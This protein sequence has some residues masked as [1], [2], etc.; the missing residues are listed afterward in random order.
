MR[1]GHGHRRPLRHRPAAS[2]F[3]DKLKSD[4]AGGSIMAFRS[5]GDDASR[6][7][8]K[9]FDIE[10]LP[11]TQSYLRRRSARETTTAAEKD[12][13]E[14]FRKT[15]DPLLR[16]FVL[17]Q[18]VPRAELADC[19]QD[20]WTELVKSLPSF[21]SDGE[22]GRLCSWL[23]TIARSRATDLGRAA[24][25]KRSVR[26]NPHLEESITGRELD[27]A[28]SCELASRRQAVQQALD[29]LSRQASD[30]NYRVCRLRWIE[31]RTVKQIAVELQLA[32]ERVRF[33]LYRTK[34][35]LRRILERT[36][37]I[38]QE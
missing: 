29:L 18:G 33:R 15:Y 27:P 28:S 16:R 21:K 26:L 34:K 25:R 14:Q 24:A 23:R 10:R 7:I 1:M 32:P 35:K 6:Q 11:E 20:V 9:D 31:E 8:A 30:L 13:F 3:V 38:I 37:L 19:L 36:A 2:L 5:C 12:A 22:E 4:F 17:A